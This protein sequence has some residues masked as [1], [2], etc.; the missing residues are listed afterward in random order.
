MKKRRK[1]REA[2]LQILYQKD[3]TGDT[4]LEI[5]EEYWKE[6]QNIQDV[7]EFANGLVKGTL[8]NM[9]KIDSLIEKSSDNWVVSRMGVVDRNILRMAFYEMVADN[10]IPEKVTLDE[11]IEIAK[12]YG[13]EDSSKFINGVLDKIRKEVAT[14]PDLFKAIVKNL[15]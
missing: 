6:L 11:A 9:D 12:K 14:N 8:E 1:A 7:M 2:I 4:S 5:S 15:K 10:G 3:I 13:T